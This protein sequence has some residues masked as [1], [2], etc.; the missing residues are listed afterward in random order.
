M[1]RY[2]YHLVSSFPVPLPSRIPSLRPVSSKVFHVPPER[3]QCR[4]GPLRADGAPRSQVP[5]EQPP[6]QTGGTVCRSRG[7]EPQGLRCN[8]LRICEDSSKAVDS[9]EFMA[10]VI[11]S[12]G[13][14]C[15]T[16]SYNRTLI[17]CTSSNS[18]PVRPSPPT[19]SQAACP[20][21][22]PAAARASTSP[23]RPPP[24]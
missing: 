15:F 22:S 16:Y 20:C 2:K 21:P 7:R 17:R 6:V 14:C 5:R 23:P 11:H 13:L 18:S 19:V 1:E 12:C 8:T 10:S 3:K 24:S 9:N 4:S